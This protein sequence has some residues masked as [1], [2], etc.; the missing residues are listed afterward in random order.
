MK[1]EKPKLFN[2]KCT[3][4]GTEILYPW[5]MCNDCIQQGAKLS[6]MESP[7]IVQK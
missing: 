7:K 3:G 2:S 4:C 5:N 6:G 1:T